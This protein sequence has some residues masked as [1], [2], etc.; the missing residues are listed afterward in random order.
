[1]TLSKNWLRQENA[2]ARLAQAFLQF[3]TTCIVPTT[4]ASSL[5]PTPTPSSGSSRRRRPT[6]RCGGESK[7]REGSSGEEISSGTIPN[8]FQTHSAAVVSALALK[9]TCDFQLI[10]FSP[11]STKFVLATENLVTRSGACQ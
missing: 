2:C 9:F 7:K 6:Q 5:P 3:V 11:H 10:P 8:L 4:A 1:M